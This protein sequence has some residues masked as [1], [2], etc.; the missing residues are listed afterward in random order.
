MSAIKNQT[1]NPRS[2]ELK[3]IDGTWMRSKG[4]HTDEKHLAAAV[5]QDGFSRAKSADLQPRS[6]MVKVEGGI[7]AQAF[8]QIESGAH[9]SQ[10]CGRA[11]VNAERIIT[12]LSSDDTVN[13]MIHKRLESGNKESGG[14]VF[15]KGL[16]YCTRKIADKITGEISRNSGVP[17][18][19]VPAISPDDSSPGIKRLM[20]LVNPVIQQTASEVQQVQGQHSLSTGASIMQMSAP[21]TLANNNDNTGRMEEMTS[22]SS[23]A[24]PSTD[25][26]P[27]QT[28]PCINYPKLSP[29]NNLSTGYNPLPIDYKF[30]FIMDILGYSKSSNSGAAPIPPPDE[31]IIST[32]IGSDPPQFSV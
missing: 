7:P 1:S 16:G 10:G 23:W 29:T 12:E 26:L 2:G 14:L 15:I 24:Q 5:Q 21:R 18:S 31:D 11:L 8:S 32:P 17:S 9:V 28:G 25:S 13:S 27:L 30:P 22:M 6:G 19:V 20:D 3:L 4:T